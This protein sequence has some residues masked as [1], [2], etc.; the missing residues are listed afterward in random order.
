MVERFDEGGGIGRASRVWRWCLPAL[1][2]SIA[3][4]GCSDDRSDA[5]ERVDV[6]AGAV[7]GTVTASVSEWA[8]VVDQAAMPAGEVTFTV[9]NEGTIG[10]EFLVVRTD[11]PSGEIPVEGE[12]F[13]EENESLELINE[14]G[15]F[16]AGTTE[17]L[18]LDLEP[19]AYQ[20]VC[21]LSGHYANGMHTPFTV[22]G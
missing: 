17:S 5:K 3:M 2:G 10:H 11:L 9:T 1:V 18:S 20:L 4:T 19:G 7:A 16:A 15:E 8:V 21:N 6:G 22:T 14:I 13:S 12:A